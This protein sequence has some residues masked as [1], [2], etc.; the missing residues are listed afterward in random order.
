MKPPELTQSRFPF[1]Y[2]KKN[3]SGSYSMPVS[4]PRR[5][6]SLFRNALLVGFGLSIAACNTERKP[7]D[8][9]IRIDPE[10]IG[11]PTMWTDWLHRQ[12]TQLADTT[13]KNTIRYKKWAARFN[14]MAALPLHVKADLVH[15]EVNRTMTYA[16]DNDTYGKM[17]YYATPIESMGSLLVQGDCEDYAIAK[18][19][20]LLRASVDE[21]RILLL[22]VAL[23]DNQNV[24][25]HAVLAVDTSAN[26]TRKNCLILDNN[27]T[28]VRTL[29]DSFVVPFYTA[30]PYRG[31][32]KTRVE[33]GP[34]VK[35]KFYKNIDPY[36]IRTGK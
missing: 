15:R 9:Y 10:T 33:N 34:A 5:L 30:S 22:M 29:G 11:A 1:Y 23:K 25:N 27:E 2:A 17:E 20:L 18:Y 21:N 31:V 26:M 4:L 28:H 35:R 6:S 32:Q 16:T 3:Q 36:M 24:I 8:T 14:T 13:N 19:D 12:N 7:R